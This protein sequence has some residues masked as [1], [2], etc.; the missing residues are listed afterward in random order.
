LS[1]S[2]SRGYTFAEATAGGV[3]LEEIDPSTMES[4]VCP[5]LY[6]IGEMLDVDGASAASASGRGRRLTSQP[7]L[8]GR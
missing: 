3:S 2:G 4:R 6:L 7:T 1:V 8:V 5:G